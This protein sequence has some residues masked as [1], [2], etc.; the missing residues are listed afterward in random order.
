[1]TC[2]ARLVCWALPLSEGQREIWR[3]ADGGRHW[4]EASP[5]PRGV[6][7]G[8]APFRYGGAPPEPGIVACPSA[9]QCVAIGHRLSLGALQPN[10]FVSTTDGGADLGCQE[11]SRT[12]AAVPPRPPIVD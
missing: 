2:V 11:H 7:F 10:V 9:E 8:A 12:I 6:E 3:S 5:L 4:A 1:V